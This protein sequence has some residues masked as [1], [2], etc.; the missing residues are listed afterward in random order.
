MPTDP[1]Q[2]DETLL[3]TGFTVADYRR[4]IAMRDRNRIA[5]AIEI[6]FSERY[7]VPAT[8][9]QKHGFAI[10][11]ISCLLLEA[12]ESFLRGWK[13]STRQSETLFVEF[14]DREP[15][16]SSFRGRG[17]EFF[18][19][20]R[21]GILH[22]GETTNGWRIRRSGPL[23]DGDRTINAIGFIRALERVL[24]RHCAE[25]RAAH[26]GSKPWGKARRKMDHICHNCNA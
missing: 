14:L 1:I 12:L 26:W 23:F 7:I 8:T 24:K 21:C 4:A 17:S 16:F 25:L 18:R 15:E 19:N 2:P 13:K 22:Q 3:A 10:I 20:V 11:A 5:E 9:G 6:R